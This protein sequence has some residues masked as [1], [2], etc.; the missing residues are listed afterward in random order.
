MHDLLSTYCPIILPVLAV[1]NL[2][3]LVYFAISY[4]N[5]R[6]TITVFMGA[7][8]FGLLYDS[9]ILALGG[10]QK[11]AT[12]DSVFIPLSQIRFIS[13]GA[14]IPFIFCICAYALTESGK[15]RKAVLGITCVLSVIGL[16]SGVFTIL[17]KAEVANIVRYMASDA[18]PAWVSAW[19]SAF[20]YGTVVPLIICGII[21]LIKRRTPMLFLSGFLMFAFAALGPATGNFD[22]IFLISMFGE[23]FMVLF[24]IL[25]DRWLAKTTQQAP[26]QESIQE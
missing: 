13:H 23:A 21:L 4:K 3:A 19:S 16:L 10:L 5:N 14:I 1:F 15:I 9:T 6:N 22:L 8:T 2:V 26:K 12:L 11:L 20:S 25:H 7:I 24:F 18:T 17:E